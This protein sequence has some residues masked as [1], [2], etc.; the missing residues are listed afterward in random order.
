MQEQLSESQKDLLRLNYTTLKA[1]MDEC[2]SATTEW[3]GF[4]SYQAWAMGRSETVGAH[5]ESGRLVSD[6]M[7]RIIS[8]S[9]IPFYF[10][11]DQY[12]KYKEDP[13]KLESLLNN[14]DLVYNTL[15]DK[16][17]PQVA[18]QFALMTVAYKES[19]DTNF[20]ETLLVAFTPLLA[21]RIAALEKLGFNTERYQFSETISADVAM[22]NLT[23]L[24]VEEHLSNF[25]V[26]HLTRAGADHEALMSMVGVL[27]YTLVLT[28][29]R[30]NTP[31]FDDIAQA[32]LVL[33]FTNSLNA[34]FESMDNDDVNLLK[35]EMANVA[36]LNS[37]LI[38]NTAEDYD[39]ASPDVTDRLATALGLTT[40]EFHAEQ[41]QRAKQMPH[42]HDHHHHTEHQPQISKRL[43]DSIQVNNNAV[44]DS[45]TL[46]LGPDVQVF[47][48]KNGTVVLSVANK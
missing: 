13:A 36:I 6:E 19:K 41:H 42:P 23:K 34:L 30:Y 39:T 4:E 15:A 2:I 16:L 35:E 31:V 40:E 26:G 27:N 43:V 32:L 14:L 8:V 37:L 45:V 24:Y 25:V 28:I 47:D 5:I 17:E 29:G 44:A 22:Y 1:S 3:T 10:L 46:V 18:I 20:L 7:Q 38:S 48:L 9:M 33:I 21:P 12:I 11:A